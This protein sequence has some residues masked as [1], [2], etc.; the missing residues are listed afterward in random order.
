MVL[1]KLVTQPEVHPKGWG[2]ELWIV[3]TS[4]YCSKILELATGKRCSIH[5]HKIK[6]ET[7]YLLSGRVQL[8][9][10]HDEYQSKPITIIMGPNDAV[11]ITPFLAHQFLGLE[12]SRILEVSTQHFE[13]DSYRLVKGD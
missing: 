8:D 4:L 11:H 13:D 12:D 9:L 2:R 10:Y 5:Y 7:F 3:N 1:D 6:D